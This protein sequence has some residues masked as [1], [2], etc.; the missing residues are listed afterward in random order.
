MRDPEGGSLFHLAPCLVILYFGC[1]W[2]LSASAAFPVP[3]WLQLFTGFI[4]CSCSC[5]WFFLF[6]FAL[7]LL[8]WSPLLVMCVAKHVL[9]WHILT[10]YVIIWYY[11]YILYCIILVCCCLFWLHATGCEPEIARVN[12]AGPCWADWNN[13]R[14]LAQWWPQ[15]VGLVGV[16]LGRFSKSMWARL[17]EIAT[18]V[19]LGKLISGMWRS[20]VCC[21][22]GNMFNWF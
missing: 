21:W 22:G 5:L 18:W 3:P 12:L 11:M 9:F 10:I 2:C 8:R 14:L 6:L 7:H 13:H 20:S 17:R 15:A 16:G 4:Y 1:M 19:L